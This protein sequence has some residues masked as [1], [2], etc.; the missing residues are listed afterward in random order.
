[1]DEPEEVIGK[2]A[3]ST[4]SL[5]PSDPNSSNIFSLHSHVYLTKNILNRARIFNLKLFLAMASS[6]RGNYVCPFRECSSE[7][8]L[9]LETHQNEGLNTQNLTRQ[10]QSHLLDQAELEA[11]DYHGYSMK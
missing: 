9:P 4:S 2:I 1:M 5:C 8:P 10:N 6:D 3:Q 7:T 11:S